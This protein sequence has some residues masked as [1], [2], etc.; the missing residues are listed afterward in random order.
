MSNDM[1]ALSTKI[2][3]I[4]YVYDKQLHNAINYS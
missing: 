1:N 3:F 4:V 2:G